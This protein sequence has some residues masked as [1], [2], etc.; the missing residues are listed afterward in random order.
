MKD[1]N[2]IDI[3]IYLRNLYTSKEIFVKFTIFYVNLNKLFN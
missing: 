3:N 1:Y 2:K